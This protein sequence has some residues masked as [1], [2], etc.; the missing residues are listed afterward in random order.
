MV[1][2]TGLDKSKGEVHGFYADSGTFFAIEDANDTVVGFSQIN[3]EIPTNGSGEI[4]VPRKDKLWSSFLI[5]EILLS[6]LLHQM[7]SFSKI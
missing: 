4:L 6:V 7:P 5:K 2:I 1:N 3:T